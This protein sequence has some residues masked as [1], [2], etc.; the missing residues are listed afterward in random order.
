[1]IRLTLCFLLAV[2]TPAL[3]V[4]QDALKKACHNDY[5]SFCKGV[6]PGGGHIIACLKEH[7]DKLSADCRAAL[8]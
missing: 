5:Q 6:M 7:N 2:A 8:R 3:A 4:D 1:M